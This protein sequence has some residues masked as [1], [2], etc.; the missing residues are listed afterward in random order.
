MSLLTETHCDVLKASYAILHDLQYARTAPKSILYLT[1]QNN[2]TV[3]LP[4]YV[5]DQ[6]IVFTPINSPTPVEVNTTIDTSASKIGDQLTIM[7]SCLGANVTINFP[8]TQM[9]FS[10]CG[11]STQPNAVLLTST[12]PKIVITFTFDGSQFVCGY[13]NC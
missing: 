9:L 1:V 2:D 3:A 13:D 12:T 11:I 8:T 10:Q 7:A 6:F 5:Q 4:L